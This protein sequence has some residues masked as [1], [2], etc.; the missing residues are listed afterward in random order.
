MDMEL[1]IVLLLAVPLVISAIIWLAPNNFKTLSTLHV[2]GAI[3]EAIIG[4][5]AVMSVVN[6]SVY[7]AFDKMLFIDAVGG[8]FLSLIA[9][10]GLLVNLYA[11]KYMQWEVESKEISVKDAKLFF[12]LSHLF[13]FTMTFSVLSNNIVLMWVAIEAT[14]LSSVF[15]VA[16]FKGKRSTESGW[17]YIVICSIGLAFALYATVLLYSAGYDVVQNSENIMLWTTLLEHA[18]EINHD[19]LKLIYVFAL[20]GFGTKAGLAPTHTWLPD[21]HAEGPAPTSAL[22]SGVLLKCAMLGLIRYYAIV[23]NGVGL[24]FVQMIMLV[25]GT[26]TLFIAAFFLIRQHNVKRMFAYHSIAHMGVIAFGLGV[27]GTIGFFAALFHCAAHSFT[28]ALAFCSTG[29]IAKI[30]GTKDMTK[31]GSM[32]R[33]APV[34]AVLFGIAICSL[35]GVPGFAIFVSEFLI[36]KAAALDGQYLLMAIFAIALAII[37]IADFS[38]FFLATFGK[39]EGKVVHNSE[40]KLSENLPLLALAFLIIAFGVWQFE[41]FTFLLD[42][43]VKTIIKQ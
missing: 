31:M 18:K 6:G 37:F 40:M 28:K 27:S 23:A 5:K 20:I 9:V 39:V 42:E 36:F 38:H 19:A 8:V 26:L 29:N 24:E 30:Y 11:V 25:S 1:L 22:L 7:Y 34:T 4:L 12:A 10:T 32:I 33:I 43:S 14:T 35:V 2:I 15:M 13:I 3:I 21:V 41:S 16:L 17:K